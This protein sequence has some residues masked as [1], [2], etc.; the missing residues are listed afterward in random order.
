MTRPAAS[1]IGRRHADRPVV[2]LAVADRPS[3]ARAPAPARPAARPS[4]RAAGPVGYRQG[5]QDRLPLGLRQER[6]DALAA[7]AQVDIAPVAERLPD[8]ADGVARLDRIHGREL[9]PRRVVQR[10]H[11]GLADLG[12]HALQDGPADAPHVDLAGDQDADARQVRPDRVASGAVRG[13]QTER[14]HLV[15]TRCTALR[16]IAVS[17]AR[18]RM[19]HSP[20]SAKASSTLAQR[21]IGPRGPWCAG[22][23]ACVDPADS[24]M[25]P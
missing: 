14:R 10:E 5:R 23:S 18:S 8:V 6:E 20:R 19:P 25:R 16:G 11:D 12:G 7:R 13:E 17:R 1:R 21:A 15:T 3:P 4:I 24:C 22:A 9:A 2:P